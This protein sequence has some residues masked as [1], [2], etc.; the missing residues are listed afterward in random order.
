MFPDRSRIAAR[1]ETF[2]L[3]HIRCS[4][5]NRTERLLLAH[6]TGAERPISIDVLV[7][8]PSL[9]RWLLF[10]ANSH[11]RAMERGSE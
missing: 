6:K 1:N 9:M 2:T 7:V 5:T 10:I 8:G 3:G 4:P 11:L